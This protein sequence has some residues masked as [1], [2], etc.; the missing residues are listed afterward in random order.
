MAVE[1]QGMAHDELMGLPAAVPLA[2][3]NRALSIGRTTGYGMAKRGTYPVRVL[4]CG[5]RYRVTRYDLH[6]YRGL[7][8]S[9]AAKCRVS[10]RSPRSASDRGWHRSRRTRRPKSASMLAVRRPRI[11]S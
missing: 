5:R 8:E 6:R 10:Q 11:R 3:A 1:V 9:D 7:A 2:V 4:R